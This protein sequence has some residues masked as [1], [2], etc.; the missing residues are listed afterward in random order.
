MV[1]SWTR[2]GLVGMLPTERI[3]AKPVAWDWVKLPVMMPPPSE[4]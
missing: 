3:L 2:V 1:C 4:R